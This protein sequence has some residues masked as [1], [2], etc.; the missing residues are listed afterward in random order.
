MIMKLSDD[1]KCNNNK[2]IESIDF[3][4]MSEAEKEEYIQCHFNSLLRECKRCKAEE[5]RQVV[6]SAFKFANSAHKGMIRKSG[7]PYIIHPIE[8]A[9]IV[10]GEIGFGAKAVAAALLHDV[11]EDTAYYLE[12]IENAFG[13]KIAYLVKGLTKLEELNRNPEKKKDSI[14]LQAENFRSLIFTISEDIRVVYIK[15]ADRLHNMRT[16]ESMPKASQLRSAAEV[17]D[18]Y[19]PLAYRLGLYEI[20]VELENLAFKY[21]DEKKFNE[22]ESLINARY[23]DR[24]RIIR[25]HAL[26]ILSKLL[27]MKYVKNNEFEVTGR[28]KTI[29]SIAQKM[30][31]QDVDFDHIFDK[32]ALRI[33]FEPNSLD[34]EEIYLQCWNLAGII[35]S[36]YTPIAGRFRNWIKNPKP[37]GYRAIHTTVMTNTGHKLEIQIRTK[38]MNTIAEKGLASHWNYKSGKPMLKELEDLIVL[39]REEINDPNTDPVKFLDKF[40]IDLNTPNILTFTPKGDK[41]ILKNGS[42]PVDFAFRILSSIGMRAIAAKV[43][44]KVVALNTKLKWGDQVEIITSK[45]ISAKKEWLDFVVTKRP[46]VVLTKYFKKEELDL[47]KKGRIKFRELLKEFNVNRKITEITTYVINSF[48]LENQDRFFI[49]LEKKEISTAKLKIAINIAISLE[50]EYRKKKKLI[51]KIKRKEAEEAKE[52]KE[53]KALKALTFVGTIESIDPKRVHTVGDILDLSKYET[54][55]CCKPIAGDEVIGFK[56]LSKDKLIIHKSTCPTANAL[57]STQKRLV[58]PLKWTATNDFLSR[59]FIVVEGIDSKGILIKMIH[60]ISDEMNVN[61][62]SLDIASHMDI[63]K[64]EIGLYIKDLKSLNTLL[65]KVRNIYGVISVN[66]KSS[67]I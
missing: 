54:A 1:C 30:E 37:N 15:I 5:E 18:V 41:I 24:E 58:V 61:M 31:R 9:K 28:S 4:Q 62:I 66:R 13:E 7:E 22:I 59:A 56:E 49:L 45:T 27:D 16:L 8:V 67:S 20:K 51:E 12:D 40:K 23:E 60:V 46:E 63:F 36:M 6:I 65:S 11:V 21:R 38:E 25:K 19:A 26:Q 42:T 33:V 57:N 44:K 10:A 2:K 17:L 50:K 43:D 55:D 35:E 34:A 39:V 52:T 64:G 53:E 3:S 47:S 48:E 32:L 29:Y 14:S